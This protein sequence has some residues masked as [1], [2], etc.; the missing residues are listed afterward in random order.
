ML[1]PAIGK[2][3]MGAAVEWFKTEEVHEYTLMLHH[4]TVHYCCSRNDLI[5]FRGDKTS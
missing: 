2:V 3:S 5:H 1:N 4:S